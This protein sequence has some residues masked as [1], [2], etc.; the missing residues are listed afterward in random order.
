MLIWRSSL[1][2]RLSHRDGGP[3]KSDPFHLALP[4]PAI[5]G[6]GQ[7]AARSLLGRPPMTDAFGRIIVSGEFQLSDLIPA[8]IAIIIHP[9]VKLQI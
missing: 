7:P 8:H 2:Q 6:V 1:T 4:G 3:A 9:V 5:I